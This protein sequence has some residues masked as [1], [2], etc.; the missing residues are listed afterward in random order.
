[1]WAFKNSGIRIALAPE[2]LGQ[3]NRELSLVMDTIVCPDI[4]VERWLVSEASYLNYYKDLNLKTRI[5]GF[6]QYHFPQSKPK[7]NNNRITVF[8]GGTAQKHLFRPILHETIFGIIKFITDILDVFRDYPKTELIIKVHPGDYNKIHILKQLI[9]PYKKVKIIINAN[10]H[11]LIK[12][13]DLIIAYDT[14]SVIESLAFNKNVVIYDYTDRTSYINSISE[15]LNNGLHITNTKVQLKNKI[16]FLI[17]NPLQ[18]IDTSELS[19][20]LENHKKDYNINE[21]VNKL[22]LDE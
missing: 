18:T 14:S 11:N 19:M 13:S 8:L 16:K 15:F 22:I 12:N 6:L 9:K 5:T 17:E 4:D 2:G 20:V 7:L 21:I 1:M 3:P 10:S